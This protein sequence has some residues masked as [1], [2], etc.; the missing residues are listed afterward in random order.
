MKISASILLVLIPMV[1]AAQNYQGMN[2]EEMQKVMQQ[3]QKMQACMQ[4]VD[5]D[6]LK[7][8][9][10]RSNQFGAEVK[11]LCTSGKRDEAQKKAI[12]FGKEMAKDPSMQAMKKCGELSKGMMQKMPFMDQDID[13]SKHHVCD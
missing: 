1:A 9:E 10:Q 3:M 4:N 2:E 6:K 5:Q 7:V 13:R 12:S 11:S 8:L